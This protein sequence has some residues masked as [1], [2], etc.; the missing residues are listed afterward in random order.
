MKGSKQM[1]TGIYGYMKNPTL[2]D[3]DG[4]LSTVFFTSGCNFRCG[5]CHNP[6]LI[7]PQ[8]NTLTWNQLYEHCEKMKSEW[9]D[10]IVITGGEPT[11]HSSLFDLVQYF[12]SHEFDVKVDTNGSYP[13]VVKQLTIEVDR[14]DMDIKCSLDKYPELTS[15]KDTDNIKKSVDILQ[16]SLVDHVFRTTLLPDLHDDDD[17]LHKMG[18]LIEGAPLYRLQQF[19]PRDNLPNPKYREMQRTS[20]SLLEHAAE[21]LDQYVDKVD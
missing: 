21:I 18:K 9:V 8:Q 15:F 19:V 1:N 5:Y 12:K 6:E 3:F 11:L 2:M 14:I 17:Q 20:P 4:H 13:D 7:S 16:D 10:G